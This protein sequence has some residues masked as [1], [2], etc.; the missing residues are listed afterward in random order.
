MTAQEEDYL[1]R[2]GD[3]MFIAVGVVNAMSSAHRL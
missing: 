1:A 2:G 3:T